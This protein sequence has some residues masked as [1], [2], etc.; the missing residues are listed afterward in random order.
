[1]LFLD[2]IVKMFKKD[3]FNPSVIELFLN[4]NYLERKELYRYISFY[5]K[6]I[7]GEVL[8]LGCGT[9]PYKDFFKNITTYIGLEIN[10]GGINE[11]DYFYDGKTFPFGDKRF[12]SMVSF[13]VVY[14]IPNLEDILKEMNRVIKKDGKILISVP[15]IWFDGGGNIQRRFSQQYT[16]FIFEKFGFQIIEIK[17]TNSNMSALC[18]LTN[19][20]TSYMTSK[21]SINPIRKIFRLL[22]VLVTIPSLNILGELFLKFQQKDN[23]LYI[24]SVIYAK[25]IIDV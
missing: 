21:I 1:M 9:K 10:G 11:A 25:K 12:D 2:W 15:F 16:K 17:Q 20:Y 18:L 13:Q 19:K 6:S 22:S 23:E 5:S 8:D 7:N 3:D 14:Q 4:P 24:D